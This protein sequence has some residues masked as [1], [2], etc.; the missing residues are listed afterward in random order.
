[1][2]SFTRSLSLVAAVAEYHA[3]EAQCWAETLVELAVEEAEEAALW[4][5]DVAVALADIVADVD[6]WAGSEHCDPVC[7]AAAHVVALRYNA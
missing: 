1:M 6:Y 3:E 7:V 5:A 2:K 4:A